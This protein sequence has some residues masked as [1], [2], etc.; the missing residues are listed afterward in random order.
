MRAIK[1]HLNSDISYLKCS[2]S[3][4]NPIKTSPKY[5][6]F[7]DATLLLGG[8]ILPHVGQNLMIQCSISGEACDRIFSPGEKLDIV[9]DFKVNKKNHCTSSALSA[10]CVFGKFLASCGSI[11]PHLTQG[12]IKAWGLLLIFP[13]CWGDHF[14][15]WFYSCH[16]TILLWKKFDWGQQDAWRHA[17]NIVRQYTAV[18]PDCHWSQTCDSFF[19]CTSSRWHERIVRTSQCYQRVKKI[20]KWQFNLY[21]QQHKY[22]SWTSNGC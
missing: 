13:W 17:L 19:R 18:V 10:Q 6:G 12:I 4:L 1:L 2:L 11:L 21:T 8:S 22:S 9:P 5:R 16:F 20:Y 3:P 7:C 15:F 14:K